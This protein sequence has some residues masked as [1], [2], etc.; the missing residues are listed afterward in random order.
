MSSAFALCSSIPYL[1]LYIYQTL[2]FHPE[3]LI[4]VECIDKVFDGSFSY[5]SGYLR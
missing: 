4:H 3:Y 5:S 2:V 1:L